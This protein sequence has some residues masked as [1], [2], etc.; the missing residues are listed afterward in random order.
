MTLADVLVEYREMFC[1]QDWYD[2]HTF[3]TVDHTDW[4][5]VTR[6]SRF[7]GVPVQYDADLLPAVALVFQ[8]LNVPDS[9]L[10]RW[11]LWT[12]D[13]DDLGQRVYVG[14]NGR[15]IEIHRHIHLTTRFAIPS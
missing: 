12:A 3:L 2:G 15:G 13:L 9:P 11:Y 8:M 4:P 5:V 14:Q 7:G 6:V 1:R 10:W